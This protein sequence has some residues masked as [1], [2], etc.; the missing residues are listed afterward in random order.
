MQEIEYAIG[1]ADA[2]ILRAPFLQL[3]L[4]FLDVADDLL[5]GR[6]RRRRQDA[7]AQFV[8]GHDRRAALADRD[9]RRGIGRAH[10][11]LE[12][13]AKGEHHREHGNHRVARAG[14][15]TDFH[16]IGR[17]MDGLSALHLQQHAVFAQR[18]KH[19]GAS[20]QARELARCGCDLV[21]GGDRMMRGVTQFLAVR[22]DQGGAAIDR[23]IEPLRD[24]R[25]PAFSVSS[26]G[27]SRRG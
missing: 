12:I 22:R 7:L 20:G 9:R 24:R 6:E 5:F 16:R 14:N 3:R 25:S 1:E 8:R 18:H 11:R 23:V 21:M 17:R 15:V 10:R 27:R 2:Q 13:G 26:R 4:E 19:G